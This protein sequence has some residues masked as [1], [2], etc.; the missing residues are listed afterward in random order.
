MK[1]SLFLIILLLFFGC[2]TNPPTTTDI[3][4]EY[5]KV[6]VTSNI[7]SADIFLDGINTEKV[8]PDTIIAVV[9]NH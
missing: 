3:I 9:G 6:I 4:E 1:K 5:G 7:D 8:T 2:E